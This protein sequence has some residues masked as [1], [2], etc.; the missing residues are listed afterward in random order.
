MIRK[1]IQKVFQR[2]YL[3]AEAES[4]ICKLF[5]KNCHLDDIDALIDLQQAIN[6]GYVSRESTTPHIGFSKILVGNF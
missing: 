1:V 2:E 4:Q 6:S 5:Y 3:S